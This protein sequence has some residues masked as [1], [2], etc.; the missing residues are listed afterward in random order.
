MAAEIIEA[1]GSEPV[2][3]DG[4]AGIFEVRIDGKVVFSKRETGR[5]PEPGEMARLLG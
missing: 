2:L 3:V 1:L 5:F 4:G